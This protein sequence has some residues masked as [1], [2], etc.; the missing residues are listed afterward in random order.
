MWA[1]ERKD[2][3]LKDVAAAGGWSDTSTLLQCYQ[4]PD[5]ETMRDVLDYERPPPRSNEN[6]RVAISHHA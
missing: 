2:L 5:A 1:T 6:P 4:Q 3:P